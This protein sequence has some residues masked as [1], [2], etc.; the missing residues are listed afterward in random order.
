MIQRKLAM[1]PTDGGVIDAN[2]AICISPN[3]ARWFNDP[4]RLIQ[5]IDM[6]LQNE[7]V[8]HWISVLLDELKEEEMRVVAFAICLF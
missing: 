5:I 3:H 2:L 7:L 6:I 4:S 8:V 1:L